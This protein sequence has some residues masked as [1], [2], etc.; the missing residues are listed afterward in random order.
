MN[1]KEYWEAVRS[2]ANVRE[3]DLKS[4]ELQRSLKYNR[5][6][7][8]TVR[9]HLMDTP[10]QIEYN[11]NNYE[12]WG[13]NL[14]G[15][16]EYGK[17]MIFIT[18]EEHHKIH[19][20]S[21][22]TRQR[23]SEANTGKKRS[24][25]TK[26]LL[27]KLHSGTNNPMYGVKLIGEKNGMYGKHHTAETKKL[28]SE[29]FSGENNPMFGRKGEL[30][31]CYGRC[32]ELNPMYGKESAFK[33]KHHTDESK[34]KL[35]EAS[36][37]KWLDPEYR[38]KN[39]ETNKNRWTDEMRLAVSEKKKAYFKEHQVS[40]EIRKKISESLK[41]E[42]NPM[43]G[44]PCSEERKEKIRLGQKKTFDAYKLLYKI[45]KQHSGLLKRGEFIRAIKS[46]DIIFEIM[47]LSLYTI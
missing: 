9:H 30:S 10:E 37:L 20:L 18:K 41:G 39:I 47:P 21:E 45:Y 46:G 6:P 14:D 23:I 13:H 3:Y 28:L 38:A 35:S 12:M 2:G 8:A 7:N 31:P 4:R 32:G 29:K 43:Y 34:Q 40:D 42:K 22:V 17:Y 27:S 33:G 25:K 19:T 1:M 16:F 11:T 44:K 24:E 26:Q 36:K 5:D 15:T